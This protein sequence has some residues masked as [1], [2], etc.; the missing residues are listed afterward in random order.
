MWLR[1]AAHAGVGVIDGVQAFYRIHGAQM[2]IEYEGIRDYEEVKAAFDSVLTRYAKRFT[3]TEAIRR[4]AYEG[5]AHRSL[6]NASKLFDAGLV[7]K[8]DAYVTFAF[9]LH[10]ALR[11]DPL[12]T[13]FKAKRLL[14]PRVWSM[15]RQVIR[16][17]RRPQHSRQGT[18]SLYA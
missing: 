4:K 2:S 10:P 17:L 5:L 6:R 7:D 16:G 9:E 12:W 15:V 3:D 18:A 13:R 14:G 8:C 1:C 11:N